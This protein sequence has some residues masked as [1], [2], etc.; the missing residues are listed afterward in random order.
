MWMWL[1]RKRIL[2]KQHKDIDSHYLDLIS[3]R[4]ERSL[5]KHRKDSDQETKKSYK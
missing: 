2:V 3:K 5:I 4:V 1:M